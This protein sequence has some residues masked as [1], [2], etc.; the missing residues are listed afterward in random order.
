[1]GGS[2]RAEW[3]AASWIAA[4]WACLGILAVAI[5]TTPTYAQTPHDSAEGDLVKAWEAE[6]LGNRDA[7]IENFRHAIAIDPGSARAHLGL[8][9][10]LLEAGRTD[11]AIESS[12]PARRSSPSMRSYVATSDISL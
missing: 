10:A 7:A 5:A 9:Y 4:R 6:R 12:R 11:A 8:A 2:Y 3:P 1:M